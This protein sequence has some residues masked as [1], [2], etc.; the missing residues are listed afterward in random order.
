MGKLNKR[1]II[2]LA[3]AALFVL[4]ALYVLL[5]AGPVAQKGGPQTKTGEVTDY[6][7]S[8]SNDLM[9]NKVTDMDIYISRAAEADWKN[10]P[11]W[12]RASYREFAG[13]NAT[14]GAQAKIIYSG[15]IDTGG[16]KM[17]IINGCEYEAGEA[18]DLEGYILEAIAPFRVLIKNRNTGGKFSISLQE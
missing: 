9:K 10:N 1:Q 4:Y 16:K 7:S 8:L 2:I 17:A 14:G 18:L 12:E 5:I 13:Q 11:F 3:I 15:Y 6:V